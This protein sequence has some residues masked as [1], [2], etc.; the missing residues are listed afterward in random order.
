MRRGCLYLVA[1]MDWFTRRVLAWKLCNTL[2]A[3]FRVDALNAAIAKYGPPE[4]MSTDQGSQFTSFAQTDRLR[5]FGVHISMD[6]KGRFLDNIFV[7]R[8]W[9]FLK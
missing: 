3:D 6:G 4:I 9:R 7:E 1:I 5:R 2:E 8:L